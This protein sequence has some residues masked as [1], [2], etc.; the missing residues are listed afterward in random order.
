MV[1]ITLVLDDERNNKLQEIRGKAIG[2]CNGNISFS[3]V[4]NWAIEY[5]L[6]NGFNVGNAL[7][8][9]EERIR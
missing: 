6:Q 7:K 2:K 4:A 1:R 9:R 3:D 5:A 8:L